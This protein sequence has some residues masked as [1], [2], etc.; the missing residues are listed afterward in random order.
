MKK[1]IAI[2]GIMTLAACGGDADV[3]EAPVEEVAVAEVSPYAGTYTGTMDDGSVWSSV[4]NE[5]GTYADTEA[6]EVTETGLWADSDGQV[7]FTPDVAE[8]EEPEATSCYSMGEVAED[9]SVVITNAEGEES[10]IQKVV[11]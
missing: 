8:G 1:L 3:D 4:L 10:T 5:D 11:S 7:C 2:A 6:G 9:G